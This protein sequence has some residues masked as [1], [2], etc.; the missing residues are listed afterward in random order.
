MRPDTSKDH[1][2]PYRPPPFDAKPKGVIRRRTWIIG[3]TL[4]VMM[5]LTIHEIYRLGL[6]IQTLIIAAAMTVL[7]GAAFW[8]ALIRRDTQVSRS[9]APFQGRHG[10]VLF[11]QEGDRLVLRCWP[12]GR[13]VAPNREEAA[14][15]QKVVVAW[16]WLSALVLPIAIRFS[17]H[18]P[19]VAHLGV[20]LALAAALTL[21]IHRQTRE[22]ERS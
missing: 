18:S 9:P 12:L 17:R 22:W 15:V 14:R 8:F 11:I 5:A 7:A 4:S 10:R 1:L 3:G 13:R 2:L 21:Y 19:I 16:F 6:P 20:V